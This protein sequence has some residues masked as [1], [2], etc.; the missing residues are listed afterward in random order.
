MVRLTALAV[1]VVMA[2]VCQ[3][4]PQPVASPT[5]SPSPHT[6]VADAVLQQGDV[7]SGLNLCA[8]SGP[9]D[10]YITN[11]QP[12]QPELAG[13]LNDQWLSLR[14]QGATG[15]AI[16]LFT[17]DNSACTAELAAVSKA[18]SAAAFVAVFAD[19]GQADRAW[20]TGVLGFAPPAPGEL[21]PGLSRGTPTG[22]GLSAWTYDRSPVRLACWHKSVFVALVVLTNLDINAFKA[23]TAAVNARLN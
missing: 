3:S 15:A 20:Q 23:A 4:T 16:S 2:G 12:F 18:K 17:S 13:R 10:T 6:A 5:P 1:A 22:L 19:E 11:L 8:G 14:T 7:P 21:P 9:F